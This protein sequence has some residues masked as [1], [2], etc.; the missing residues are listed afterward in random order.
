MNNFADL[1]ANTRYSSLTP[2]AIDAAKKSILDT[3][4]VICAASG[5]EP[6]LRSIVDLLRESGGPPESS[7]LGFGGRASALMAGFA[8]GAMAH[9]LDFDDRT[10]QGHHPSS[11]IV[12]AA[13]AVAERKGG[14]SG[15]GMIAAVAAGQDMF[16][17]LRRNVGWRQDFHLT[18]VLGVFSAAGAACHVLGL[19][20]EQIVH[21]LGIASMQ[22]CGLS[23]M[24]FGVGTDLR[25]MYAGFVTQ[26][27]VLA[28]LL[29][30]KGV[31]GI[32]TLFEGKAG[33]FNVYFDG[34][35]NREAILDGLGT[36]YT[37]GSMLYKR[38]PTC[39]VAFTYIHATI[40]LMKQH[41]IHANDI[42]EI[43]V[44][45]GDYQYQL[46]TPLESRRA[47]KT[48]VDA[49]FSIP[50]CVAVAAARGQIQ[51]A[52][53]AGD[54][55]RDP[56]ILALAGKVVPVRDSRFDWK[57]TLPDGRVEMVL[58]DGRTLGRV[59]N[60]YPGSIEAPMTWDGIRAKFRECASF[61]AAPLSQDKIARVEEMTQNL[62]SLEDATQLFRMLA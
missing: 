11:S 2:A 10:P 60:N 18:T 25:G 30:E 34:N 5:V 23:E 20:R 19:S 43:R 48:L 39:G 36:Q 49:K 52:D 62:E 53:F 37:G 1:F 42:E 46:C 16:I 47:P 59:G 12:P 26:G 41:Q 22:S 14:V 54:A 38:W 24:Q 50:F 56:Q 3:L 61:A 40:E 8:N 33:I 4:G 57:M 27:A 32:Q 15:R 31:T 51:I 17:R 21:A 29:A 44:C 55:L 13:F 58:R 7:V 35:Y 45:V 6:A 9:C 28:A